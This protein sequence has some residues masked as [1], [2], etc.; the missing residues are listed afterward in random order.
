M[1][2]PASDRY[3]FLFLNRLGRIHNDETYQGIK[4]FLDRLITENP[5]NKD[6]FLTWTVFTLA[7]LGIEMKIKESVVILKKAI[8]N[9][10]DLEQELTRLDILAENFAKFDEHEGI[11]DILTNGLTDSMPEVEKRC[12]QLLPEKYSDFVK[13]WK[14]KKESTN[15]GNEETDESKPT[16]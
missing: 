11:K 3:P 6:L 14:E 15:D 9:L 4:N 16:T 7:D 2:Q 13:E 1:R 12:L 8:P 10:K 5:K